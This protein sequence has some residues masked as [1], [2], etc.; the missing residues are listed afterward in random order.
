[1]ILHLMNKLAECLMPLRIA[2]KRDRIDEHAQ[3]LLHILVR[4]SG[5]W[6]TDDNVLLPRIFRQQNI[7]GGQ[8]HRI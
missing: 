2:A 6:R 7:V 5:Y 4:P 1:M 8:Q 3:H